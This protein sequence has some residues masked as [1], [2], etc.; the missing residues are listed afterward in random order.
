MLIVSELPAGMYRNIKSMDKNL[1][2]MG[3]GLGNAGREKVR[4][5]SA[6]P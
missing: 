3:L 4:F 5:L 6:M 2:R 1:R